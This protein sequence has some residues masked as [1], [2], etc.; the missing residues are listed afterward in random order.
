GHCIG[1][2]IARANRAETYAIPAGELR[3]LAE[4]MMVK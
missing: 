4:R 2:N 1:M 3:S